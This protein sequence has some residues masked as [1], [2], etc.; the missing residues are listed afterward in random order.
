MP[1]VQPIHF[2]TEMGLYDVRKFIRRWRL[3]AKTNKAMKRILSAENE[4]YINML[5]ANLA[6][7]QRN[8]EAFV[9]ILTR[10]HKWLEKSIKMSGYGLQP[11]RY[12]FIQVQ[13]MLVSLEKIWLASQVCGE[14]RDLSKIPDMPRY[15]RRVL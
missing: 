5:K 4:L 15:R 2:I 14:L 8:F 1:S 13:C 9:S 7:R 11:V 12:L 10:Y 6:I 3:N